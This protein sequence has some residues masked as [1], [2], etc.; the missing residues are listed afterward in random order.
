MGRNYA[1]I[2]CY[3]TTIENLTLG[4]IFVKK[5]VQIH[6]FKVC[7]KLKLSRSS[8]GSLVEPKSLIVDMKGSSSRHNSSPLIISWI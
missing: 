7:K 5:I 3:S 6:V 2:G 4:E 8:L 1:A